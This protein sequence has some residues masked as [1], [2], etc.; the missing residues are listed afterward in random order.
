MNDR[1]T[2]IIIVVIVSIIYKLSCNF[3]TVIRLTSTSMIIFHMLVIIYIS[4]AG[5]SITSAV[6]DVIILSL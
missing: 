4:T 5:I 3:A 6:I 1:I 2:V